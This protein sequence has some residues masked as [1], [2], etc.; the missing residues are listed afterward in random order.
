M[1]NE[2]ESIA[3]EALEIVT[4]GRTVPDEPQCKGPGCPTAPWTDR[5]S[6]PPKV[7]DDLR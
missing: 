6:W 7:P 2:I 3:I 4:G 5:P 1:T